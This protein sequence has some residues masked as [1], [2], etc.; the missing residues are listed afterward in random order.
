M[1]DKYPRTIKLQGKTVPLFWINLV[2][3]IQKPLGRGLSFES[4]FIVTLNGRDVRFEYKQKTDAL[5][6]YARLVKAMEDF[7]DNA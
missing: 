7:W 1:T 3:E 6:D 4:F 5:A 2:S